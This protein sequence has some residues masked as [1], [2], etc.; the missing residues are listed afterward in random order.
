[1]TYLRNQWYVAG[2][3]AELS[4]KPLGR[5]IC[6]EPI[7]FFRRSDGSVAALEDRCPHRKYALSLGTV[8]GD[9]LQCGYHGVQ[10]DGSGKCTKVPSQVSI[11]RGFGARAYPVLEKYALIYIWMGDPARADPAAAYDWHW[12]TDPGWTAVH[13]YHHV[14]GHYQL[15]IDNL[16][17]LTHL[18]IV[19]K[20]TL[21][22][23]GILETPLQVRTEGDT[24]RSL[25]FMRN[26]DPSPILTI[27][28]KFSGKID[29]V[30][31]TWF[32]APGYIGIVVHANPTGTEDARPVH[33]VINSVT[34]ETERSTHYF[35]SLARCQAVGD[36]EVDRI[37]RQITYKAFDEDQAV[38]EVQQRMIES[39]LADRPLAYFDGDKASLAARRI[40]AQKLAE[41]AQSRAVA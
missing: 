11:P 28:K 23:P 25:R 6:G 3:A 37:Y 16:L 41:E 19:H 8:L 18:A 14:K 24:V 10:L 12:N 9:E 29:R 22:G 5:M 33:V 30:Q 2:T 40:I 35:W 21:A 39:D 20:G 31:D 26:V 32:R 4:D 7:V 27:Y 13:G 1:M 34:P 17:D 36:A 38:I 15:V